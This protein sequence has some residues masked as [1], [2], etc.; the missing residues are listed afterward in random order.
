MDKTLIHIADRP[1]FSVKDDGTTLEEL[2]S[3]YVLPGS[4]EFVIDL[5]AFCTESFAGLSYV[6]APSLDE[7]V[8]KYE[9]HCEGFSRIR[10]GG[11]KVPM[12]MLR[13]QHTPTEMARQSLQF[14]Q[15]VGL[16]M[17]PV[18]VVNREG[19]SPM[20]FHRDGE[21]LGEQIGTNFTASPAVLLPDISE[22]HA[23]GEA[24]M[25]SMSVAASTLR[26]LVEINDPEALLAYFKAIG[27]DMSPAPK[28]EPVQTELPLADTPSTEADPD[29][30]D[31]EL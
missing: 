16:G 17:T 18:Y 2:V 4:G 10:L 3:I 24:L 15:I 19:Q 30:D 11:Q 27:D 6:S 22:V 28:Q 25:S 23:K 31:E 5:P 13:V 20:V 9:Q 21:H 14:G 29:F 8:A 1:M 26:A 12:V 7:A